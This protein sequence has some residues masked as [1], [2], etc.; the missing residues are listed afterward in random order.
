MTL[1]ERFTRDLLDGCHVLAKEHGYNP[2][3]FRQMVYQH[4]GLQAVRLLL[5]SPN[6]Q[7][8]LTTLWE[9]GR[10]DAS[11]EAAVHNPMYAPLFTE[12]EQQIALKRLAA[13]DYV[14]KF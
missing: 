7:E 6:F 13:L 11:V 1:E 8:G 10:L 2:T 5:R 4:G 9:I 3:Y 14:P 12:E